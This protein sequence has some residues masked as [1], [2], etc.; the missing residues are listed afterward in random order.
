[1]IVERQLLIFQNLLLIKKWLRHKILLQTLF[2]YS[3]EIQQAKR[4]VNDGKQKG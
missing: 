1:M 2:I 3:V 4:G